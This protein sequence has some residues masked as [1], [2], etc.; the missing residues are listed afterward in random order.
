[1][2]II[3]KNTKSNGSMLSG[4]FLAA[5]LATL[6]TS[7]VNIALTAFMQDFNT[8]LNTAK[9]TLTGFMLAMG[10]VAP[11]T[12]Y[13]GQK[14]SNKKVYLYAIIGY[15][16][17]SAFCA[18]AW[19]STS[20]IAFR[21]LQG[22]F[23]GLIAPT[24]MTIIYQS[25]PKEKQ[26]FAVS[27]WSLAAYLAPAFGPTLSGWLIE[28]FS[29]RAIFVINIPIGIISAIMIKFFV[30]Y[31]KMDKAKRFDAIGFATSIFSSLM[32]LIAFSES[33]TWGWSSPKTISLMLIG[34]VIL[35]VFIWRELHFKFPI[36]NIRVFKYTRYTMSVIVSC[37]ITIALYAGSLLTPLFL[38][39]VQHE[40]ALQAGLILLP[41]SLVMALIMPLVG[42]LYNY[43]GPRILIF[44]GI[45]LIALGSWEMA[46]LTMNTAS[47]YIVFWMIVRNIGISLS[48][49]P[50]TNSGMSAVPREVSGD[51]SSVN[52]WIRQ[53]L[54]SLS[55]G[56]F[57]SLLT[58]RTAFHAKSIAV[59]NPGDKLLQLK[60]FTL[61]VN[62]IYKISTVI[63]LIAIPISFYLKKESES[64]VIIEDIE[65]SVA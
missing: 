13:L 19:G 3:Q 7:A 47:S 53:G 49:M 62:D 4:I 55:I 24:A 20:L 10:T 11:L 35:A 32:L 25:I 44:T 15:T 33:S 17:A 40:T 16:I 34:M 14:F 26:A 64:K 18:F 22:C 58:V 51:A 23:S 12:G 30:P 38:Q 42:K 57:T 39:N 60:S 6:G 45:S 65:E 59:L 1:M 31:Y 63:I 41:A 28:T 37:I 46:H 21:I 61:A 52:N 56:I 29:W 36:L 9:W 5:F 54:A 8:D 48:T 27:L 2:K 43:V 50:S